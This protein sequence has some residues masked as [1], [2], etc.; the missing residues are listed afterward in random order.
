MSEPIVAL[1]GVSKS[2]GAVAA[3]RD[4]SLNLRRGRIVGLVGGSGSGKS[5]LANLI[6][7]LD[8]A[9]AGTIRYLGRDVHALMRSARR[10]FRAGVQLVFQDPFA[11]L[12]PR[13]TA[14]ATVEEP[15]VVQRRGDRRA[16]RAAALAALG[17][18]G[19]QPPEAYAASY[20]HALSG[21]QRQRVAIARAIVLRPSVL[22]ADEPVSMLD[23]SIRNGVLRLFRRLADTRGM[24]IVFITHDISI[25]AGLCDEIVV[26]DRGRIVETGAAAALLRAPSHPY[27]A[28][29]LAAVP[30]LAPAAGASAA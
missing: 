4:V 27:T 25:L 26:L 8:R 12:D 17:E 18:S 16:R 23:V 14:L 1:D 6:L 11:S 9:D 19:L 13:R 29:L 3:L 28:R 30:R 7:G 20:P 22:V 15:L 10:E 24:A 21:G 2:F 5:T